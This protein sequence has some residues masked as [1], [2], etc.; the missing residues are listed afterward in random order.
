MDY[1]LIVTNKDLSAG[2]GPVLAGIY[3]AGTLAYPDDDA[4]R[5]LPLEHVYVVTIEEFERLI[6]AV[7]PTSTVVGRLSR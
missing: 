7:S 2:R 1:L 6:A 3:P 4:K 5:F